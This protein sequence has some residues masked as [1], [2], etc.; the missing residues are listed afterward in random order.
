VG[1]FAHPETRRDFR[2]KGAKKQKSEMTVQ[3][4]QGGTREK[5]QND[6]IPLGF[7]EMVS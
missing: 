4:A 3:E 6:A 7:F 1:T 2:E 5:A